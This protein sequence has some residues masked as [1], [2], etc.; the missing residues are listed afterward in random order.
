MFFNT[1]DFPPAS[2]VCWRNRFPPPHLMNP[3]DLD[4]FL[5]RMADRAQSIGCCTVNHPAETVQLRAM[6]FATLVD[7]AAAFGLRVIKRSQNSYEFI[8]CPVNP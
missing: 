4:T 8:L 2:S 3:F 1:Q 6:P 5:K 7:S